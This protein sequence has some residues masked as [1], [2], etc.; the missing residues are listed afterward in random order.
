MKK[1]ALKIFLILF[2]FS[3]HSTKQVSSSD[4]A[5]IKIELSN[6]G[7][8]KL[9]EP[10]LIKIENTHFEPIT[11]FYP[12]RLIIEKLV[13]NKWK[14]LR[15]L[16]CP[17]DAPCQPSPDEMKLKPGMKIKLNWNQKETWC[18]TRKAG[19]IRETLSK[20]VDEGKYRIV[21]NFKN[22]KGKESSFSQEFNIVR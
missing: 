4:S 6:D 8:I 12:K 15:I 16:E 20:Y 13:E 18:G 19:Q 1:T 10:I 3:C 21:I 5:I 17:C 2:L 7:H 22:A 11:V 9:G 14:N